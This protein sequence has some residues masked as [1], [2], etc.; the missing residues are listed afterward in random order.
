M[1]WIEG[2]SGSLN[3]DIKLI[4]HGPK[5]LLKHWMKIFVKKTKQQKL[6]L[7]VIVDVRQN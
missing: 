5:T 1:Y 7:N 6:C 4:A 3:C 2:H